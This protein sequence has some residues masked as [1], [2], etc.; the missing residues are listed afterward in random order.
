MEE[1]YDMLVVGGG[2]AGYTAALY[3]ARAG[4]TVLVLEKLSPGGQMATTD[5]IDNYPG[6]PEGVNGFDLAM[7]MKEGASRFGAQTVSAQAAKLELSGPVKRVHTA[8]GV[9][10][11][12]TVVLATGARPRQLGLPNERALRGKGVSYC[13]TCDGMFYRGK[14]VAVVGGG[15][16][17]VA[18]GLYLSRLC[19]RVVMIHRRDQLRAPMLW[20]D[21]LETAGKTEFWMN[22]Q[23]QEL[24]THPESGRLRGLIVRENT[25]GRCRELDCEGVFLAVGQTP[26]TELLKGI[27]PLDK[28]GYVTA[29]EDTCT[30]LPGVFAAGDLRAKPL[31]QIVTAVA[32]GA[33]AAAKAEEYL[34]Q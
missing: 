30:A 15:N 16:T 31:R 22:C 21:R 34:S 4:L 1:L 3:G 12:K 27:L 11:G 25:S 14:T 13:A 19:Q 33:T 28:G 7:K 8:K 32:D 23:V 2:P 24:L 6:F 10:E 20:K 26:E 18:D 17:A 9:Y 29:G 5:V